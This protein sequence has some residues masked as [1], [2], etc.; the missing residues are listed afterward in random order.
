MSNCESGDSSDSTDDLSGNSDDEL[1]CG[2]PAACSAG[3]NPVLAAAIAG[4]GCLVFK[5]D[6][7]VRL[8]TKHRLIG[9][10]VGTVPPPRPAKKPRRRGADAEPE[11][12]SGTLAA[13]PATNL[14][15]KRGNKSGAGL[16][17]FLSAEETAVAVTE[18]ILQLT[19]PH[20]AAGIGASGCDESLRPPPLLHDLWRRG[21]YVT[22]A[23][24]FGGEWLCYQADPISVHADYIVSHWPSGTDA[25][26]RD[27]VPSGA[28]PVDVADALRAIGIN[29]SLD[30]MRATGTTA[31]LSPAS[32]TLLV[33][34]GQDVQR[35]STDAGG[36]ARP[37]AMLLH[38]AL[39]VGVELVAMLRLAAQAKKTLILA[40]HQQQEGKSTADEQAGFTY[41]RLRR[42]AS[43]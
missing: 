38:H 15:Q 11:L 41:Y 16:P 10:L 27:A 17:L 29:V 14:F 18:K 39:Y 30:T 34:S 5:P 9:R 12:T 23:T 36:V 6:D 35:S 40:V 33:A 3:A 24:K 37:P 43:R 31:A 13:P 21:F 20:K 2:R 4:G 26:R 1:G 32:P 25:M 28:A 42:I 8:R 22:A 7:V 19:P